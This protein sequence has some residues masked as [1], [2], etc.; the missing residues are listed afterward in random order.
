[1]HIVGILLAA[2][3]G[4]RFGGAKLLAPLPTASHSVAAGTP[5]GVTACRHLLAAVADV[6]AVIRPGD[7]A[8]AQQLRDAG[9]RVVECQ[10]ADDGMGAS[11]ACGVTA[12]PDAD[13]WIV[14][15]ADMPWLA[16]ETI[17]SVADALTAG[18]DIAAP[19]VDGERAH[20]VG[21]SHRHLAAL[22]ALTGD[23]GA[24]SLVAANRESMRLIATDDEG[25][26]RDVDTVLDLRNQGS[27]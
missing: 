14:A 5:V 22:I 3:Q 10:R 11:L 21:F 24:K 13:G 17:S 23:A 16:P 2:G 9:A 7:S 8:L 1:M 26:R 27:A 12:S 25:A 19:I 20:P 6:V 18:A 4:T 15:L